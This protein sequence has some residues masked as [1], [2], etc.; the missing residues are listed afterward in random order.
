MKKKNKTP[1]VSV[2]INTHNGE[3]YIKDAINSVLNQTFTN[4]ELIIW[5]NA[6]TDNTQK[7]LQSYFKNKI[8]YFYSEKKTTLGIAR[9]KA[10]S[11]ALGDYITFID[12]DDIWLPQKLELQLNKAIKDNCDIIYSN[13]IFFDSSGDLKKLYKNKK[14]PEGNLFKFLLINYHLSFETIMIRRNILNSLDSHFDK[15]FEVIEEFDLLI[16]LSHKFKFGYIP[17]VLAKW[18]V[19]SNSVT[20]KKSRR[21][22]IEKKLF[23]H[24]I[25]S[26]YPNIELDILDFKKAVDKSITLSC[27]WYSIANNNK[28]R[29]RRALLAFIYKHKFDK[30]IIIGYFITLLPFNIKRLIFWLQT[31]SLQWK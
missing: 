26:L 22:A 14:Q 9:N 7:L 2:I 21:I 10:I 19:R 3:K 12:D 30:K 28:K 8:K 16:R 13:S 31:G 24:K 25:K 1:L 27:F 23:Y 4:Y 15:R 11:H 6:S 20:W 29:A 17:K 5:D 18:R